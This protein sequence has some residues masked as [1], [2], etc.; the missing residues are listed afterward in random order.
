MAA[1]EREENGMPRQAGVV[2]GFGGA[3]Q[4]FQK[5]RQE[6]ALLV[7]AAVLAIYIVLGI[8]Y[9]SFLHP[10]TVLSGLPVAA[11][12]ALLTLVAT[13]TELTAVATLG[14]LMLMGIA[15]KNAI[16][17]IDVAI[18]RRRAGYAAEAAIRE[19]CRLRFR[20]ILMTTLAAVAGAVPLAFSTGMG[21]EL[22]RPLGLTVL[23]GLVVSQL[24]TLYITP[25]IYLCF[26]SRGG[27]RAAKRLPGIADPVAA[28]DE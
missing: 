17:M 3:A 9:E 18:A 27:I 28:F 7:A 5:S 21:A 13:G 14:I 24:L 6:Q 25:A 19:A 1:I 26:E 12:G 23:G 8:L 22:R 15:K 16:M 4:S 20:P 2:T 11:L 10:V